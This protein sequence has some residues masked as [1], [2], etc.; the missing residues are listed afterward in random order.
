[1]GGE[2]FQA[3]ILDCDGVLF[4][5]TS[6]NVAFY[7][8]VLNALGEPPLTPEIEERIH[9]FSSE[10]L[11]EELF[12]GNPERCAEASRVA[13][14]IDYQP[15]F[16]LMQPVA[17]LHQILRNLRA[18]HR[19]AMATNRGRTIPDLLREFSLEATF[20]AVVGIQDVPRP[21]PHPDML[22]ECARRLELRPE[23]AVYV[24]DTNGDR[25]A[26]AAAGMFFI[27][28]GDRCEHPVVIAHIG[29][30]EHM[31][32]RLSDGQRQR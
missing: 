16:S 30:L 3:V 18:S 29:E 7:T 20:D 19:L 32:A 31:V 4:D 5:S 15:F 27:G 10:Q 22:I 17:N 12:G 9:V 25:D 2:R 13:A 14:S 28:V 21:K 11:F 1:M 24:G 23:A 26:A 6:A 8:A